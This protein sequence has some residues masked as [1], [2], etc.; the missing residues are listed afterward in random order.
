MLSIEGVR[1]QLRTIGQ[2]LNTTQEEIL[3]DSEAATK[4]FQDVRKDHPKVL[5]KGAYVTDVICHNSLQRLEALWSILEARAGHLTK[6]NLHLARF[7]N[8]VKVLLV[9]SRRMMPTKTA[10]MTTTRALHEAESL[11]GLLE[12][13]LSR[14]EAMRLVTPVYSM[15]ALHRRLVCQAAM[16]SFSVYW[17]VKLVCD[18]LLPALDEVLRNGELT[19]DEVGGYVEVVEA[20]QELHRRWG[21]EMGFADFEQCTLKLMANMAQLGMRTARQ[22]VLEEYFEPKTNSEAET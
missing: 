19:M 9:Q 11:A 17:T 16:K 5:I 7:P 8:L 2:L 21:K 14:M 13:T 4:D 12:G 15:L 18:L 20:A 1:D 10:L 3:K 22:T 6:H